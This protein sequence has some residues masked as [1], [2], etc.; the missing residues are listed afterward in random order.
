MRGVEY[1]NRIPTQPPDRNAMEPL[2]RNQTHRSMPFVSPRQ[3]MAVMPSGEHIPVV[4]AEGHTSVGYT[5][6]LEPGGYIP[7]TYDPPPP[8]TPS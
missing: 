8:Y 6:V 4:Q 7:M 5:P 2:N 3:N 1:V